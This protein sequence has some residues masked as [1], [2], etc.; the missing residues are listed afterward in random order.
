MSAASLYSKRLTE[1]Q[2]SREAERQTG[3]QLRNDSDRGR[4][5]KGAQISRQVKEMVSK[6]DNQSRHTGHGWIYEQTGGQTDTQP[7]T[8]ERTDL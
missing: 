4:R 1:R 3:R 2:A 6:S 8:K 5:Q 7:G